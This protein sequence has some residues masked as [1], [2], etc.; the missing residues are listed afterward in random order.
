MTVGEP[1]L[2]SQKF[3]ISVVHLPL[4]FMYV[5]FNFNSRNHLIV[6]CLSVPVRGE[7]C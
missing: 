1:V 4:M 5:Q 2:I 3:F 7:K 6:L